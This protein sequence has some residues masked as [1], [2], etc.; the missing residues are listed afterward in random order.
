MDDE[1]DHGRVSATMRG[2]AMTNS[3]N[4]EFGTKA[5][6]LL[7]LKG[8]FPELNIPDIYAFSVGQWQTDKQDILSNIKSFCNGHSEIAVRSSCKME[9]GATESNAGAFMSLLNVDARSMED[10][11]EAIGA[12]IQSYETDDVEDQILIQPMVSDV[13]LSGVIMTR[14]LDDGSPYYTISYDDESGKTDTITGGTGA[15]KTL[16]VFRGVQE[17][18]FDSPRVAQMVELAQKLETIFD[19]NSLDIEFGIDSQNTIHLF[20]VRR[21]CAVGNWCQGV[22]EKVNVSL[23]FVHEF[24]EHHS[25]PKPGLHGSRSILGIM[26]DWN[27]AE[28]IGTT[29]RPLATSLYRNL[30]TSRVWSQARES[31][32]YTQMPPAELMVLIA[33]RPYI[34]VR[35]S[36]NSFLPHGVENETARILVDA[37]LDRLDAN[38]QFH[39]KVEFEILTTLVDLDFDNSFKSKYPDLL[40]DDQFVQYKDALLRLTNA[41]LTLEPSGSLAKG[42]ES[43]RKL[44]TTQAERKN[45]LSTQGQSETIASI[46]KLTEECRELGTLPF[47]ILARHGFMAES[48]LRSAVAKGAIS[49][50][51]VQAFKKSV[52]TVS[53][54]LSKDFADVNTGT[55][56]K[57]AF[58]EKYGHLRPGTYDILSPRYADRMNIFNGNDLAS[59]L[60]HEPSFSPTNRELVALDALLQESGIHSIDAKSLF[61][62]AEAAI[63]GREYGKFVFTRN[64]SDIIELL[65]QWGSSLGLDREALSYLDLRDILETSVSPLLNNTADHFRSLAAQGRDRYSLGCSLKLSYLIR[66]SRDIYIVPVHRSAPNFI[67]TNK[68]EADVCTLN[69]VDDGSLDLKGKIVCIENADPGFDWI[70]TKNISGLVTKFGGTNSHMA[71]R[72]AEFGLPAAIGCGELLYNKIVASPRCE[73]DSASEL[74]RPLQLES[75]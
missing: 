25:M 41:N 46:G 51:R 59:K 26:P 48:L 55:M 7:R 62:Y 27:P 22:E 39:D 66:S 74:L 71:I 63:A 29:A 16:Y 58:M 9:D 21:I 8:A 72:C 6:T 67:S 18:D 65:A 75:T 14:T 53:G 15:N 70:F 50:D 54:E 12:V 49:E 11:T 64:L 47:S 17:N 28:I 3:V 30:I 52:Q 38:P 24:L 1:R 34:D 40:T 31:M 57:E 19:S 5:N 35:A 73:I 13:N 4:I 44:A 60:S 37:W 43:V 32:G 69:G 56:P 45:R 23:G 42:L 33:G 2:L 36:F 10:I 61:K 20:Q 68:I